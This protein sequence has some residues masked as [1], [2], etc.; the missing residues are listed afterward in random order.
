MVE[1]RRTHRSRRSRGFRWALACSLVLSVLSAQ[2]VTAQDEEPADEGSWHET[3]AWLNHFGVTGRYVGTP[4]GS[5]SKYKEDHN[6]QSGPIIT[7]GIQDDVLDEGVL[8]IEGMSEP[9]QDQ[10][11]LLFSL[12][13]PES[14]SLHSNI[15]AW[16]EYYNKR[17]GEADETALG[18]HM[19][20]FFPNTNNSSRFFAGGDP[21]VDWLRTNTGVAVELPGAFND[22]WADFIYRRVQGDMN[23]LKGGTVF[24]P[25]PL[26]GSGLGPVVPGSG[27]GTVAF[28]VSSRKDVDYK[29]VGALAGGRA[30]FG[31]TNFQVDISGMHHDFESTVSETNFFTDQANSEIEEFGQDTTVDIGSIDLVAS[32]S[33]R[34]DLFV[35]GGAA[36]SWERSEPEPTQVVQSGIRIAN[37]VRELTRET[38]NSEITRWSQS[39][40]GGAVFMP[41]ST[42]VVRATGSVRASQLNGDLTEDRDESSFL[43]GDIGRVFNDS[44]RDTVSARLRLKSDWRAARRLKVSGIVQYDFRYEDIKTSRVF[45]FVGE[46]PE[47]EKYTNERST[48]LAG[49]QARYRFRRGRSL[50][51]GYE[52]SYVTFENDIDELSNQLIMADYERFRHRIHLKAAGRITRKLHAELRGQYVF[53]RRDLDSP[54]V[55]PPDFTVGEDG[56]IEVQIVSLSPMMTYQHDEHWSGV[57]SG[58]LS[59][60]DYEIVDAGPS[61]AGFSS[62]FRGFEYEAVT[63]TVTASMNWA[64][65]EQITNVISYTL[66]A[67]SE[68]V[69]NV[70]HD[71]SVRTSYALDENWDVDGALRYLGYDPGDNNVVDDYHTII[72]SV[73]VTGRF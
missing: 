71:A 61:P 32:R 41:S 56:E 35:F 67:N 36:F 44:D 42:V 23:L 70:G 5:E 17:T 3:P 8:F 63:G 4:D 45:T 64:P 60:T 65:T 53:E 30:R 72:A 73:G 1:S 6:I 40:N 59:Y 24:D 19:N 68:S 16:R 22:V 37:P 38:V 29:S 12:D 52:F 18:T 66:Y 7:L 49:V 33:L 10:G 25:T 69:D 48:V 47:I 2:N 51:G 26:P 21:R 28:D 55:E 46:A 54:D 62:R 57:L 15:Q 43:T 39:I 58:S 14:F 27:P 34:H 50:E 9:L 11:Y 20:T 31:A 13:V